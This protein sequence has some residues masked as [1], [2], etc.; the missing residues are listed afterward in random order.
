MKENAAPTLGGP[1]ILPGTRA[2]GAGPKLDLPVLIGLCSFKLLLHLFTNGKYGYF[3]DELY[4]LICGRH[5]AWGYVDQAP[6]IALIARIELLFGSSLH[7]IRF[8]PAVAGAALIALTILIVHELGGGTF[9]QALAGLCVLIAPIYLV[10]CDFLSM[11]VFEPLFWMGCIYLLLRIIKTHNSRLWLW[12]GVL[13]GLGIENKHSAV[14]FGA[15]VMIGLLLTKERKHFLNPWLWAGLLL[16]FLIALP[17]L[18]WQIQHRFPTYELLQN[19]KQSD[20]NRVLGP[21][22][23]LFQQILL[24]NPLAFVVWG[25]GLGYFF[26]HPKGSR[27]R[28]VGIA[29]LALFAIFVLMKG[30]NY[31]LAPIYAYLIAGGAVLWE[32]WMGRL[33]SLPLR[34]TAQAAAFSLLAVSGVVFAPLFL[35]VCSPQHLIQYEHTIHFEPPKSETHHI[36]ALPQYFGDQFGWEEMTATVARIYRSLPPEE[37]KKTGIFANNYGEASALNFFGPRYG[38]PPAI[39]GHQNYFFWGPQGFTGEELIVLQDSRHSLEEKCNSVEEAAVL[40]HPFAMAEENGP[41]YIC[42]GLKW[43]LQAIWPKLKKWH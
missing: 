30:K 34:R 31:Y 41:V 5:L 18:L 24:L 20:K 2:E 21:V 43:N 7:V 32:E 13:A 1:G 40:Y 22:A 8:L 26:F 19:I 29:Y 27:Y 11:N 10:F 35:P 33:G 28:V 16:A 15:A 23:Y 3:R 39:S 12:F 37:R 14:F 38:L 9:A 36:G 4:Y 25:A 6:L 17:N 42:R